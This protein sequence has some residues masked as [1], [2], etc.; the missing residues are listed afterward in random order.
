MTHNN[1]HRS[2]VT[3]SAAAIVPPTAAYCPACAL[4][5]PPRLCELPSPVGGG[6]RGQG[7][8]GGKNVTCKSGGGG[9]HVHGEG[10]RHNNAPS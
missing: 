1:K 3:W 5:A 2:Y 8:E 6:G 9:L 7:F 4:L 10:M